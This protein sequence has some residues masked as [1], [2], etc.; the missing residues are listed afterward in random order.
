[1]KMYPI[2]KGI[3]FIASPI[4]VKTAVNL[5][6]QP[7]GNFRLPMVAPTKRRRVTCA[8]S[9]RELRISSIKGIIKLYATIVYDKNG[10]SC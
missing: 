3:F 8:D 4:P 9:I 7:G 1:M 6:G 2:M 5:I 10:L